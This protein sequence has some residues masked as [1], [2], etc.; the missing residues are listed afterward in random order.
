MLEMME[1]HSIY[2]HIPFCRQRCKYC[3]FT[4]Y[5]GREADIPEYVAALCQEIN[6]VAG[7]VAETVPIHTVYFGGGTPSLLSQ[8]HYLKI[9]ETLKR[10]FNTQALTEI[11]IEANPGTVDKAYLDGLLGQG[12]NRLSLGAQSALSKEL[13]LLGRIHTVEQI[14]QAFNDA[15]QA[16][17]NNISLDFMYGL[18]GQT[19]SD[20][21]ASLDLAIGLNPEHL[22]CYALTLEEDTPMANE[23]ACGGLP[24]LD[25]DQA[26]DCYEMAMDQLAAAG[27]QQYEIS[28]WALSRH[29]KLLACEHNLEYWHNDPYLGFGAGAHGY[30]QATRTANVTEIDDY[31]AHMKAGPAEPF[32]LSPANDSRLMIDEETRLQEA[33]M[34]GLRL[35]KEGIA[36]SHFRHKYHVDFYDKY[37]H[38]V[39][40]LIE[41]TLLEWVDGKQEILRLTRQGRLLGNQ[42]FM[43]FVGDISD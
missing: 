39:D 34:V 5:A 17:F 36:R 22:S 15:R 21:Q 43:Q 35:T 1:S 16:G 9:L 31:L 6:M 27:Y 2:I 25:D 12:I 32:P 4:T 41:K 28:N 20:W 37:H 8:A 38:Q 26:A 42:V 18:P 24:G 29:G 23:I 14:G 30:S 40:L 19:T 13:E 11:S 10:H 3:D 7:H 33:M